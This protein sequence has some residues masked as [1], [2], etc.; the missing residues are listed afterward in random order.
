MH[1]TPSLTPSRGTSAS[2]SAEF[3]S[4]PL[5]MSLAPT[6]TLSG[7]TLPAYHGAQQ[8]HTSDEAAVIAQY[9]QAL[10]DVGSG[11]WVYARANDGD[12]AFRF[13][14]ERG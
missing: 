12:N 10:K 14:F 2:P 6:T 7:A 11:V 1:T 8:Q 13:A 9:A 3:A 5:P 4:A